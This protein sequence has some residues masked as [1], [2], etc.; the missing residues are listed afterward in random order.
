MTA[1]AIARPQ[2]SLAPSNFEEAERFANLVA[3]SSFA[4]KGYAGKPGDVMVAMQMGAEL[5][6]S[7]MQALQNIAVI[8]GRPS[9][10]GDAMLAVCMA[11]TQFEDIA[12]SDDGNTATCTVKRKGRTPVTRTFSMDDAKAAGLAGKEGPWRQYPKRMRQM[13]AR[14]FALRDMFPDALRGMNSAEE[15]EDL[16]PIRAT[17]RIVEQPAP[18][19][20]PV[21]AEPLSDIAQKLQNEIDANESPHNNGSIDGEV[22]PE[23]YSVKRGGKDVL[24]RDLNDRQL[25][26]LITNGKNGSRVYA[27][28]ALQARR[29]KAMEKHAAEF[30][31][32]TK[33]DGW[34]LSG[35]TVEGTVAT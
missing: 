6:L 13:R 8:S 2:F 29:E 26:W 27:T 28:A 10:W 16:P 15:S 34:G 32:T 30:E 25:E 21:Q 7:P 35:E 4:P 23:D 31:E 1:L 14:A 24:L 33:N 20:A 22:D 17:A 3:R 9:L 18:Q 19:P 5:G 11:H 12:E